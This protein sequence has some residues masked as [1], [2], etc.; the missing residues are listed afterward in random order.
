MLIE[1]LGISGKDIRRLLVERSGMLR[2]PFKGFIHFAHRTFQEFLAA[3]A[4]LNEDDIGVLVKN[5]YDDQWREVI[6]LASGLSR[7]ER[8]ELT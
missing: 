6:I 5:A 3:Q 1:F 7:Q 4:V 8:R 2:E